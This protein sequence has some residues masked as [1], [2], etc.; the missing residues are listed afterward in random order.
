MIPYLKK[1][2]GEVALRLRFLKA[3]ADQEKNKKFRLPIKQILK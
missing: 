3:E 2:A 1:E